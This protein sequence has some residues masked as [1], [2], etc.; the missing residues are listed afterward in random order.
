MLDCYPKWRLIITRIHKIIFTDSPPEFVHTFIEQTLQSGPSVSLTCSALGH[1]APVITWTHDGKPLVNTQ[2]HNKNFNQDYS[3]IGSSYK[4]DSNENSGN[5]RH[6][7]RGVSIG[8]W[9]DLGGRIV[10]QVNMTSV[11]PMDG[12]LYECIASNDVGRVS[13]MARLNVF[14]K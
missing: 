11:T 7:S 4:S 5:N 8:S 2:K 6:Y 1:P 13:H 9:V 10:G 12:G 3:D 14:G